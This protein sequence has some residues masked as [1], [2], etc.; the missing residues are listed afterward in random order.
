MTES[1]TEYQ[2]TPLS[3]P[4]R[5]TEHQWP[6]GTLPLVTITCITYQHVN[7]IR[8]AI[9]GFLMQETTFPVEI[10]IHDDASTDGTADIVREYE[11]KYPRLFK[12]IYQTENQYSKG[13]KCWQFIRPLQR[14]KYIAVC[15]GDDYWTDPRKLEIQVGYLEEHPECVISSHNSF[16]ADSH[17]K[18]MFDSDIPNRFKRDYTAKELLHGRSWISTRTWVYRNILPNEVIPEQLHVL[19]GDTFLVSRLGKFGGCK[20]H[21]EI[22]PA[23]YRYHK[24]GIWSLKRPLEK[25]Y[26]TINSLFWIYRYWNRVQEPEVAASWLE[27]WRKHVLNQVSAVYL[28]RVILKKVGWGITWRVKKILYFFN[29]NRQ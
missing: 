14:G 23:C 10:V 17:G 11:T 19:N 24:G 16:V 9:E 26:D 27:K 25:D 29:S 5:I 1:T 12:V 20:Y 13:N 7:F 15:E 4:A 21:P 28:V 8:E 6:E 22:K 3:Q 18:F 2:Y